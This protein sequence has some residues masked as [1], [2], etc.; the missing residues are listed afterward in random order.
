[1]G[2][3]AGEGCEYGLGRGLLTRGVMLLLCENGLY[4]ML[5][6]IQMASSGEYYARAGMYCNGAF[7]QQRGGA[8]SCVHG[9]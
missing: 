3:D 4:G 5:A 6:Y 1:M 9:L 8:R 7:R 2:A